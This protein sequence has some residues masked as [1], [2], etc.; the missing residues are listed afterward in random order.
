MKG[1]PQREPLTLTWK[2]GTGLSRLVGGGGRVSGKRAGH[3][4]ALIFVF[5]STAQHC[6]NKLLRTQNRFQTR[7]ALVHFNSICT[8][9]AR[10]MTRSL[11]L[12]RASS[13]RVRRYLV[14]FSP[15]PDSKEDPQAIII[16]DIR[17]GQ[18]K[19][20]FHCEN[21]SVWPIFK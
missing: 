7:T 4:L 20:G 21:A 5:H 8:L 18:K 9:I 15:L 1:R 19:R 17:T 14:T 13:L 6:L 10:N 11:R 16:W 12:H 2:T 3:H